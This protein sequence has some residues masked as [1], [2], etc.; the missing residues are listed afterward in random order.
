MR[1]KD[2]SPRLSGRRP[3]ACYLVVGCCLVVI[4]SA[5]DFL[6][7]FTSTLRQDEK[8]RG[9]YRTGL[10]L[11]APPTFTSGL[12]SEHFNHSRLILAGSSCNRLSSVSE[13]RLPSS[14][15]ARRLLPVGTG[16]YDVGLGLGIRCN[17]WVD[18]CYSF[19]VSGAWSHPS[20]HFAAQFYRFP[21]W[22]GELLVVTRFRLLF[23]C[24]FIFSYFGFHF[25]CT[26]T[27]PRW[28]MLSNFL[29]W[30][31]FPVLWV[32]W[33][34]V[35]PVGHINYFLCKF[36]TKSPHS[37]HIHSYYTFEVFFCQ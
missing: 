22:W 34:S 36:S 30:N 6:F 19:D 28:F 3:S 26:I 35:G 21:S 23:V 12:R 29:L 11:C 2:L 24:R 32:P 37:L 27:G 13:I 17:D 8:L 5:T 9:S 20:A 33:T 18:H 25:V 10:L 1:Y 14:F 7:F 31:Y 4:A 16:G 15:V